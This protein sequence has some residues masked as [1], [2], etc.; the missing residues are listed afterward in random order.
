MRSRALTGKVAVVTGGSRGIGRAT[1]AALTDAGASVAIG[2]IDIPRA[3]DPEGRHP[4][5]LCA[6]LD[7][8]DADAFAAFLDLV[9]ARIGPVDILVNNAGI[10]PTGRIEDEDAR[11]TERAVQINLIGVINGTK[12]A[13]RRMKPR[14]RGHIVNISS[15][16]ARVPGAGVATY[17]AT[18]AGVL[19]FCEAAAI[20]LAG[21]GIDITV[22]QPSLVRTELVSGIAGWDAALACGPEDVAR[23]V[24]DR[25]QRPKFQAFV[26]PAVSV[27]AFIN[28]ALPARGRHALARA[29]RADKL[30][31]ELDRDAHAAY[32]ERL[33]R[34]VSKRS[35]TPAA[36]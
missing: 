24:L 10:M 28:Q 11:T 6:E 31:V 19:T 21:T 2:D 32:D 18:K 1:A 9:E 26:P 23:R 5:A 12:E 17:S 20:E 13:I 22:I 16:T 30:I 34:T 29:T 4:A 35:G 27:V 14:G 25:L 8:A 7:V 15:L 33:R 36:E 3:S